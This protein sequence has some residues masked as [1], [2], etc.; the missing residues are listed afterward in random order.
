M[1]PT[2]TLWTIVAIPLTTTAANTAQDR[3]ASDPPPRLTSITGGSTTVA[4]ASVVNCA[5]MPSARSGGG[6]SS[7]S[8]RT[9]SFFTGRWCS[10]PASTRRGDSRSALPQ[11]AGRLQ[12]QGRPLRAGAISPMIRETWWKRAAPN[13]AET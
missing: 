10:A 3:Y 6:S 11:P 8:N 13:R 1:R 9:V 5:P 12:R 7:A 2:R 4:M